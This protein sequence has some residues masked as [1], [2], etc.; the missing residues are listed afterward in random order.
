MNT[1]EKSGAP[2]LPIILSGDIGTYAFARSFY[3][4]WHVKSLIITPQVLGPIRH[5][6]LLDAITIDESKIDPNLSVFIEKLIEMGPELAARYPDTPLVLVANQDTHV[7][8][9]QKNASRLAPYYR[10]AFPSVDAIELTNDKAHF[11]QAAEK[12][13]LRVPTTV[14][15][16]LDSGTDTLMD[17][18]TATLG[19]KYPLIIKPCQSY[20]YER[21]RWPGKSKVYTAENPTR[22]REILQDLETHTAG[23]P[24]ARRFVAQPRVSG[25]DT[26]SLSITAY[27]D[28]EKRVSFLGSAHVL[29]EDHVPTALGNP[30]AMITE[31]YPD[32]YRQV[33]DFLVGIDWHGFAN[34]DVKVDSSTGQAYFFEVN[35]RIGRNLYYNTAAGNNPLPALINDIIY[36]QPTEPARHFDTILYTVLPIR[37]ILKYT[38]GQVRHQVQSLHRAGKV[39][40]PLLAPAERQFSLRYLRRRLYVWLSTQRHWSKFKRYYPLDALEAEGRDSFDTVQLRAQR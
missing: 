19:D 25:N 33:S 36:H 4:Q 12:Y 3:E 17:A 15:L 6:R 27:V 14:E 1:A 24:E 16:H 21:L 20:G 22:A 2:F 39:F 11:A 28:S 37:L 8:N 31:S 23:T 5:S 13:G 7:V 40:N 10:F 32:L 18:I 26:H 30:A 34:F 35:P 9:I 29:L 38:T